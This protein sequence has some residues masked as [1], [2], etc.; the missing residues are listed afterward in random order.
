[1]NDIS[2]HQTSG[3]VNC[4]TL[5]DFGLLEKAMFNWSSKKKGNIVMLT[6]FFVTFIEM[7][8]D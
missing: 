7:H 6:L 5:E 4:T 8:F 2:L 3:H 1:M